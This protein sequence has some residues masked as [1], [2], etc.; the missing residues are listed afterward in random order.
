MITEHLDSGTG[1][2][3]C[4]L[5]D[6]AQDLELAKKISKQLDVK[7]RLII[8]S[9]EEI[10]QYNWQ[11]LTAA[12]LEQFQEKKV[13][14]VSLIGIKAAGA[15]AQNIALTNRKLSRS[16]ILINT[17]TRPHPTAFSKFVDRIESIL[18]LGLPLRQSSANFDS[19]P[20]L[21]RLRCPALIL[22]TKE[23]NDH[24][25]AEAKILTKRLPTA[26]HYEASS[27]DVAAE[28]A[29]LLSQF[30]DVPA[31]CP[32]KNLKKITA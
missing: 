26:W 3:F 2:A 32:Q 17:T 6:N 22:T 1:R 7:S 8:F 11:K 24:E 15:I 29:K 14:Q 9:L 31:K 23:A 5:I 13:R 20:F 30:E 18:P 12:V 16:L 27:L 21:Q 28:I 25:K 4:L 10:S 19:K